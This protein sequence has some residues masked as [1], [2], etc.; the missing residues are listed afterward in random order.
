MTVAHDSITVHLGTTDQY[1]TID[2]VNDFVEW[3]NANRPGSLKEPSSRFT[4]KL[5]GPKLF[6][7]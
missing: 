4:D 6:R 3:L 5:K 1:V 7:W 2:S